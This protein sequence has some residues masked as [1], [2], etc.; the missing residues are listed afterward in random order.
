VLEKDI[1]ADGLS[2]VIKQA[3]IRLCKKTG[4]SALLMSNPDAGL[5]K[6]DRKDW[7]KLIYEMRQKYGW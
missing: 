6:T 4:F 5:H 7:E 3:E 1:N 2:E